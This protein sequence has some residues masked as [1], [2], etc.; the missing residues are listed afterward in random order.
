MGTRHTHLSLE[1]R[2]K[3]FLLVNSK[4]SGKAHSGAIM[5]A[6]FNGLPGAGAEYDVSGRAVSAGLFSHERRPFHASA[7]AKLRRF[8]RLPAL[9]DYVTDRLRAYWSPEQIA[10]HMKRQ[11][12]M[13]LYACAETIYQHVYSDEGRECGL[14]RYLF[15][16]RQSAAGNTA[17]SPMT[18]CRRITGLPFG[19][20]SSTAAPLS[21]IGRAT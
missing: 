15:R 14:Y 17:A 2:R 13:K 20:R 6:S 19:R 12:G 7:A 18:A 4:T 11:N 5:P 1:E 10:G 16:G 21:A 3:I 8:Y 9:K